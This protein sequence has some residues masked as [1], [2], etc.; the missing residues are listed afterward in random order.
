MSEIG[1]RLNGTY[2]HTLGRGWVGDVEYSH[3]WS[4][5]GGGL[6][7]ASFSLSLP[8]GYDHPS[9]RNG[10]R[11]Q[12]VCGPVSLGWGRIADIDRENWSITIDGDYRRA[13][14]FMAV[15]A[16]GLP[17]TNLKLIVEQANLRGLGWT[18]AG[19]LPLQSVSLQSEDESQAN[20][21]AAVLNR[22]CELNRKRWGLDANNVPYLADDPTS[23]GIVLRPGAS[24]LPTADDDYVTKLI[25]RYASK[26]SAPTDPDETPIP[27]QWR[28]VTAT[29]A[30]APMGEFE[31]Y[32]DI[33]D[34][35]LL[36]PDPTTAQGI[37]QTYADAL[38]AARSA[39]MR[40]TAGVTV[41]RWEL[42]EPGNVS[43]ALWVPQ[44]GLLA[45]HYGVLSDSG[46]V[47]SG[48]TVEWVI[49]RSVYRPAD[50]VVTLEPADI[51]PRT[52]PKIIAA[53]GSRT[54]AQVLFR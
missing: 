44:A 10:T 22:Y 30:L 13:E 6:Q 41:G 36:D 48:R 21:I 28:T 32:E 37:A 52:L 15:D 3:A 24:A 51:A 27:I 50:Q 19:N 8:K 39:R 42:A 25:V 47:A 14:R 4:T 26:V 17:S 11:V 1:F 46:A 18:G 20:T 45:R 29:S 5:T 23:V 12:V 43:P 53:D 49:G 2:A 54:R 9:L 38:L 35:G 31:A 34:L 40:F 33:S 16:A 7:A